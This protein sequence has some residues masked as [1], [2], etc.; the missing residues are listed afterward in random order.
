M[1]GLL[2]EPLRYYDSAGQ[3]DHEENAK[4]Y[5][6]DLLKKSG[7]DA[8]ENRRTVREYDR[9]CREI[10]N[11]SKMIARLKRFKTL[12]IIGIVLGA[13]LTVTG[14]SNLM[15]LLAG[16]PILSAS[17]ALLAAKVSPNIKN[18]DVV[19]T[20]HIAEREKL[21]AE[22][23]EQMRPL[24]SLFT[25]RDTLKLIEKTVPD[26]SFDDKF[27]KDQERVFKEKYDFLDMQNDESSMVDT[28]SGKFAGNP[29]LFCRRRIRTVGSQTYHGSLVISWTEA[30]RDSQGKIRSVRRT[31]TLHASLTKPK[32]IFKYDTFLVYGCQAAPDLNFSRS[33]ART[34]KLSEKK[35]EK[36]VKKGEEKLRKKAEKALT[37]GGSFQEMSNSEFDVLFGATDRD[38]EVQFRL[39]YTPLAQQ[40]TLELLKN[41]SYFGDDFNLTKRKRFNILSSE[42]AQHWV[43]NTSASN[44][45][46]YS[47]DIASEKFVS[48]NAKFF[49]SVFFDFA[50]L[51]AIPA[52]AEEPCASLEPI[53]DESSNY[54]YYEHEV[55]VNA[56]GCDKFAHPSSDTE[57][58]LKTFTV[59]KDKGVDKIAV[60]AYS[61][62]ACE[63]VDFVPTM[64][65]DGRLHGVP[66]TW[67]EYL[68]VNRTSHV[69]IGESKTGEDALY[70]GLN[71]KYI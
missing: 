47:V 10:D 33:A 13:V 8:E 52:Y 18:S 11:L 53:E 22:A 31:Q 36:K 67:V 21:L 60:T 61:Y 62:N 34:E 37:K 50:P 14:I 63:R 29:F 27:T 49:E 35:L 2:L 24:N 41:K 16:V 68:P 9:I 39:M 44:Y 30:R 54:T 46:S 69:S 7:I 5:F 48:S 66:V 15:N 32:P 56:V 6:E 38:N 57:A 3:K 43:M 64:G 26:F 51:I 65:G 40:N 1:N 23:W 17:I 71:V 58:I 25:D 12:L 45:H 20:K 19:R 70:H 4:Q 28:L 59:S 55:M 42:H